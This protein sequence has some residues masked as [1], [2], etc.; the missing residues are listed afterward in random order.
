MK[1]AILSLILTSLVVTFGV[2]Q[3]TNFITL[4]KDSVHTQLET[5]KRKINDISITPD[6]SSKK[7][8]DRKRAK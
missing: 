7:N 6:T 3:E 1:K 2:S 4:L 5:A 8:T